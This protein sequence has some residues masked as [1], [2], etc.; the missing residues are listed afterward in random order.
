MDE[1]HQEQA[2]QPFV[3][4]FR[5]YSTQSLQIDNLA[6]YLPDSFP[7]SENIPDRRYAMNSVALDTSELFRESPRSISPSISPSIEAL[8][9]SN[10]DVSPPSPISYPPPRKSLI[11]ACNLP[12]SIESDR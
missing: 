10:P 2:S 7:D 9:P 11:T 3:T 1:S 8:T 4:S 12:I 5:D 6:E